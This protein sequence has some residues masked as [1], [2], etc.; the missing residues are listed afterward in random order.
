MKLI[1]RLTFGKRALK[2]LH[3]EISPWYFLLLTEQ[4]YPKLTYDIKKK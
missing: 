4:C 3:K 2:W 1:P